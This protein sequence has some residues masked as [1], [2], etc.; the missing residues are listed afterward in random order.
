MVERILLGGEEIQITKRRRPIARLVPE[1]AAAPVLPD[2]MK[3]LRAIY[4]ENLL[5]VS[6]A[7][8][9]RLDRDR[10]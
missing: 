8:T 5:P 3:D 10:Y 7:E 1:L 4:G 2:F 6:G 9:V